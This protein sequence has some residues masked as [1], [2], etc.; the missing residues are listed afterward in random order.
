MPLNP[1]PSSCFHLYCEYFFILKDVEM[2]YRTLLC[3]NAQTLRSVSEKWT[4][5]CYLIEE[6]I[7][8]S[9]SSTCWR[10]HLPPSRKRLQL[11]FIWGPDFLLVFWDPSRPAA[12]PDYLRKQTEYLC[13]A[14]YSQSWELPGDA[15]DPMGL[16]R[17]SPR[18]GAR[19]EWHKGWP[20]RL[21]F[22]SLDLGLTLGSLEMCQYIPLSP[23]TQDICF[24]CLS[25]FALDF[26]YPQPRL[27][28]LTRWWRQIE[29][30]KHLWNNYV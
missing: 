28:W 15:P 23:R 25:Q 5:A 24:V 6:C 4:T 16:V 2:V 1:L 30:D 14:L 17:I 22:V 7:S 20:Q 29:P 27:S 18:A 9:D 21:P 3:Q 26:F 13:S 11:V 10:C 19:A 12:L 8:L